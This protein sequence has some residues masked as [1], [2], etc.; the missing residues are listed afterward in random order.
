MK[1]MIHVFRI[2]WT[3][4]L[5]RKVLYFMSKCSL[6]MRS[7][8][9]LFPRAYMYI[10]SGTCLNGLAKVVE[11]G[12]LRFKKIKQDSSIHQL[13]IGVNVCMTSLPFQQKM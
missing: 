3:R 8:Q 2:T 7:E 13:K 1:Q 9:D 6:N 4:P 5:E 10:V 11:D 12:N